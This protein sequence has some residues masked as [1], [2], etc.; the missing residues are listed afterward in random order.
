MDALLECPYCHRHTI[1]FHRYESLIAITTDHALFCTR[2]PSCGQR[3]SSVRPIPE[4][5]RDEVL[6]A[7]IEVGAGMGLVN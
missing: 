3:I 1:D 2:C 4:D 5:M 7:A 6:Y